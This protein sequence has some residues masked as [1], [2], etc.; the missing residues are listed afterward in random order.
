MVNEYLQLQEDS[1][2][3]CKRFW[4]INVDLGGRERRH[5]G[6]GRG[7]GEPQVTV[8]KYDP[9]QLRRKEG[10]RRW[11]GTVKRVGAE[12]LPLRSETKCIV[13]RIRRCAD[14]RKISHVQGLETYK[15]V[16]FLSWVS[17]KR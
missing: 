6:K 8:R 2:K 16:R 3:E 12:N 1:K 14:R 7:R 15:A 4:A 9:G 11:K 13:E 10:K 5:R 17:C